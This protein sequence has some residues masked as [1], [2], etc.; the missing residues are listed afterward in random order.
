M[1][2]ILVA[3]FFVL[4]DTMSR[5]RKKLLDI[6][7]CTLLLITYIIYNCYFFNETF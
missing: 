4:L 5:S 1:S 3:A 2:E 6:N 7:F